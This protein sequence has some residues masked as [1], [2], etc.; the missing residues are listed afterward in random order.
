MTFTRRA[1]KQ[2]CAE[3]Q[4]H[5]RSASNSALQEIDDRLQDVAK[6]IEKIERAKDGHL[7]M[8]K[9][10]KQQEQLLESVRCTAA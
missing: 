9:L 8:E 10:L 4:P 5:E 7:L 3:L 1:V 2:V 6:Q